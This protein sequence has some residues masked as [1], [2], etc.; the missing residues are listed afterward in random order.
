MINVIVSACDLMALGCSDERSA[1]SENRIRTIP[2][3]AI[4][5]RKFVVM[6]L[7]DEQVV[8]VIGEEI[9]FIEICQCFVPIHFE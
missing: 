8:V 2:F 5:G 6:F 1:W 3:F 9:L 7:L 4:D